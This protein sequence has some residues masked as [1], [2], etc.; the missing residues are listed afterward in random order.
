MTRSA[1]IRPART[2]KS[3][4]T[5]LPQLMATAVEANPTGAALILAA[6]TSTCERLSYEEL[7]ERSTRLARLLIDRG[8]GP[9]CLVAVGISR[10]IDSVVAVWAV[11]KSGAAF[12]PV[13]P[14][15]PK[16]A[17]LVADSGALL[18]LTVA[19]EQ[20]ALPE[21]I[22]WLRIDSIDT[23][24]ELAR[25]SSEP[26][27]YADRLHPLRAEHPAY[28]VYPGGTHREGVVVTQAGLAGL[29]AELHERFRVGFD[30]RTLHLAAPSSDDSIM[31][32]LLA[33]GG[34]AAMVVVASD[35]VG[36]A[37]LGGLLRREGVTH[38]FMN[39]AA[40][41][42]V[43]PA[44]LDE[45]RVVVA[46]GAICPPELSRRWARPGR[47]FYHGYG[48]TEAT[49]ITNIG[50]PPSPDGPATIGGP[51]RGVTEY[52]LD[53]RL[54][55]VPT[56][57]DGELYIA[58]AQQARGYHDRPGATAERFVANPFEPGSR[59][60]RT[61][62]LVRRAAGNELEFPGRNDFQE[63]PAADETRLAT[64]IH[65]QAPDRLD[66]DLLTID[67]RARILVDWNDTAHPVPAEL[68]LDGYR[69]A[70]AAHPEA[71]AVSFEGVEL[72][73]GEFD[74]R[75]NRLAR[76]LISQGVGAE[77]LVGLAVRRS[78]D[79]VVGMYAIVTA[80]GA[81]VPLDPDHP[82]ER[83]ARI[84]E[85]A[86]LDCVLTT[87]AD[88]A[89]VAGA[90]KVLA[91][92]TLD[93]AGYDGS[94]VA[95]H[96]LL[97]PVRPHHPAY[98]V[99]TSEPAGVVVSH[100]AI[101]NRI[102][103]MSAEYS[104]D[105]D[106][107]Y[108]HRAATTL[109]AAL[110]GLLLPL[111][112]GA[113]L[114]VATPDGRND[115]AYLAEVIAAREVTVT[116]FAPS[117]LSAFAEHAEAGS[118]PSLRDVFVVGAAPVPETVAALLRVCDA[119]VHSL[120]G[121]AEAA[122]SIACLPVDYVADHSSPIGVPQWNSQVYV[123]DSRLRPVPVGVPGEL[124][125]AGD[126]LARGYAHR[127][128]HTADRFVANPFGFGERIFRT[129]DQVVWR[130]DSAGAGVLNYVGRTE[131]EAEFSV[132]VD[133][134]GRAQLETPTATA[135]DAV[136]ISPEAVAVAPEAVVISPEVAVVV[137][138]DAA[139]PP[140]TVVIVADAVVTAPP[141]VIE[142]PPRGAHGPALGAI[143]RPERLPLSQ[144]QQRMWF[145]NRFDQDG[146]GSA[147]YNLPFA[148]RL[149][150]ELDLDALADA[151][152]EV[153]ARH[154]IL[155][156]VYPET[157]DGPIQV[158]LS[159]A[160]AGLA[161]IPR[162]IAADQ[163]AAAVLESAVAPF[164]VTV[165]TPMR[166]R[167]FQITDAP[168][169]Y[170]LAVVVYRIAAD[171][172]SLNLLM[173]DVLVAYTAGEALSREPLRVQYADYALWQRAVL[174]D[175]DDAVSIAGQQMLFWRTELAGV[176]NLLE[177]PTDRPRPAVAT[178]AAARVAMSIDAETR[179]ALMDLAGAHGATLSTVVRT[180]FAVVLARLSG[181]DDIAIGSPIA[182]RA[183]R[184]L[185]DLIGIFGNTLVLRTRYAG[186]ASF[187]ELLRR[188]RDSD[189]RAFAHA[190]IP[191]E[192]VVQ[193]LNPRRSTAH[194]PVFQ[195][196]LSFQNPTRTALELPGLSV[197]GIDVD[198]NVSQFDLHLI[199]GADHDEPGDPTGIDGFLTY[200]TDLFDAAT[201]SGFVARLSTVLT[202]VLADPDQP[203]GAIDMLTRAERTD[204]LAVRNATAHPVDPA[205]TLSTL[206]DRTVA[207]HAAA[208][209]LLDDATRV[210]LTY[211][212]L[213]NRANL[214]ARH[215]IALGVGPESRV[216][217]A[218]RRS[219]HLVVAMYAVT[220]AGGV[221]VPIDPD[222]PADRTAYILDTVDPIRIITDAATGFRSAS[223]PVLD[224][225]EFDSSGL[226]SAPVTQQDRRAPLTAD[227]I[228][229]LVF[230]SGSTGRPKG[231]AV[232]HR[233]IVNQL[234]WKTAEFD[235][236]PREVFL[237]KTVATF[238]LSVWEFWSAAIC[239][240]RLVVAAPDGHRDPTYL[241]ELV[242]RAGVTTLHAV[243]SLLDAL[244]VVDIAP[245]SPLRRILAI[246][247]A[248][249]AA[250]ATGLR[251][252][253]PRAALWNLYGPTEAAVSCTAHR[254][255][256][257]DIVAVPIGAPEWNS[258]VYVLDARLMPV[259]VG[260]SGELYLSGTQLAR[261]YFGRPDLTA[262]RF[263]AD[264]FQYGARMYR[265]GDLVAWNAGG[266][267][268]YR[269]RSDS[270][271]K[272]RGFRI[273]LGE[274][275]A[276]LLAL[277]EIAQAAVLVRSD[278]T[279]A[280]LV[281][282]AVAAAPAAP[283]AANLK[284]ALAEVLPSHMV[285]SA[286][287]ILDALPRNDN[288]KLDR[289]ALP[290]PEFETPAHRAPT[291][292]IEEV[293]AE[294]YGRVLGRE[295]IG[296]EDDFFALGGD[297][298]LASRVVARLGA[299]LDSR[300]PVRALFQAPTVA[301]LAVRVAHAAVGRLPLRARSRPEEIPLSQAQRRMWLLNQFGTAA[302]VPNIP[303]A[304]RL[305]GELD[306][307]ALR[308]AIA[309]VLVRHE[310]LRTVYPWT[311]EGPV[312]RVLPPYEAAIDLAPI[313]IGEERV[314]HEV[315][316]MVT[317]GFDVTGE[318]PL[319]ARLFQLG[320]SEYVLAVVV[321]RIGADAWSTG[322]LTRD[323][324]LAYRARAESA[325]PAWTPLPVQYADY[326]LWQRD[327]LA[328]DSD[329]ATPAGQQL[330]Y[331]R[332]EL[333]GLPDE[334]VLPVDRPRT[335]A[336]SFVG[337][338]VEFTV[339]AEVHGAL[340]RL[341][342]AHRATLFTVVRTALAVLLAR[343]SGSADIAV[344]TPVAGRGE[345]ELD[346][347]IGAFANTLVL[348]TE[349][350]AALS[351]AELLAANRET[352]LRAFANADIP[353]ERLVELRA[354]Q[355]FTGRHPLVQVALSFDNPVA[356]VFELSGL[357]FTPLGAAPDIAGFDLL[358]TIG[359]RRG[360]DGSAAGLVAE[361]GYA[362]DLFDESTVVDLGRR[363]RRVLAATAADPSVPVGDI[364]L[365]DDAER[366][367][368]LTRT[369]GPAVA[370]RTLPELMAAAAA[371]NPGA[372]ALI[373]EGRAFGYGDLDAAS[374]QLARALIDRGAG[375]DVL[376]ALALRRS[377][378][379]V[380][381]LWAVAKT[382]AAFLPIDPTYPADRIAHMITDSGVALGI[383]T[384]ADILSLP[385]LTDGGWVALDDRDFTVEV[386]TR[387]DA[388]LTARELRGPLRPENAAYV[389]YTSGS[390]GLPK[391]VVVTHAGLANF[392]AEQVERYGL[393]G[394]TRA[395]SFAA[396]AFDAVVLELLLAL[397]AG[398]A[399]VLTPPLLGGGAELAELIRRERVTHA[400]LTP[401]VLAALD[402]AALVGLRVV[403]SGGEAL[404]ADLAARW[405]E[406][407][408][409]RFH[410]GYGPTET[411][412]MTNISPPLRAGEPPAL[413]G[414]IR[415]TRSLVLDARLRPVPEGV[416]GELYLGGVQLARGYLQRRGLTAAR[417]VADPFGAPGERLYRT[418]DVVR[419]RRG[420]AVLDYVG[421]ND[422]QV[423]VRGLRVELGE[424]DA[425]LTTRHRVDFS[426]TVAHES[427]TGAPM[428]VSYVR[429][430][431]GRFLDTALL[432]AELARTLPEQMVPAA[433]VVLDEIPL[434]PVGKL[435]R[436]ALP[437]PEFA[438]PAYRAPGTIAAQTIAAAMG[439]VLG[440]ARV[441]LD[442]DFFALGGDS[443]RAIRV[444]SR[445]REDGVDFAPHEI[446]T[447]RTVGAL[448][449][450]ATVAGAADE[451]GELP[452]TA[453]AAR[454]VA[455]G[456]WV[457]VRALTL[458]VPPNCP[459][460]AVSATVDAVLDQHPLLW[461][462]LTG[463][464]PA[465]RIPPLAERDGEH[466]GR[467]DPER[468]ETALPLDD[469]VLAAAAALDPV[470][471]RNIHFVLSGTTL[472]VVANGLVV[473]D[474]SWRT[475]IDQLTAA[476]NRGR[477]AAPAVPESGVG[478]LVAGLHDRA[479]AAE[480]L[481]EIPWWERTLGPTSGRSANPGP[482]N[483][484]S[485]A[486]TAE[487]TEAVAAV[488]EAYH[489]TV[490]DVLLTAVA[491]AM[492]TGADTA[493]A[494]TVGPVV[495]L[496]ADG[497][498]I[499]P[500][501][502]DSM[503][504]GFTTDYPMRLRLDGIDAD[505]AL[506]GGPAAG[507]ALAAV[508]E[509]RRAVPSG[510][511][512]YGLLRHLNPDAAQR[513]SAL[514]SGRL[515][516]RYRDLR[517]ARVHTD[518]PAED[519]LLDLTV[520]ATDEGLL[521]RFDYAV[522]AFGANE[523][524]AFAEHWI[525]AL[526]GLAEHGLRTD[527]GGFG[528]S[529]FPLVSL[530]QSEIN[531]LARAYPNLSDIWPLT[532][533][534]SGIA[535]HAMLADGSLDMYITQFVLDLGGTVDARRLRAAAQAVLDR[536]DNLRVAFAADDAGNPVQVVQDSVEAP[537]RL[538]EVNDLD[539]AEADRELAAVEA[540][541]L[542]EH[543]EMGAAPLLRFTLIRS[544][545]ATDGSGHYH[546]L[547]TS[548]HI[549]VDSWSM[550]LLTRD[551]LTCYAMGAAARTRPH[552]PSYRAYLAWLAEQ[553]RAAARTAWR[554]SLAGIAGPTPLAPV[555]PGREIASGIGE[556]A[557]ELS[558]ADTTALT[559]LAAGLGVTA[560]TVVQAAWGL[561]VGR[562]IDRDD[563]VIGATVSGRPPE[564]SGVESM[565]GLFRTVIPVRVRLGATDTLGGLLRQLQT[566]QAALLDHHHLGLSEIQRTIGTEGLFDSLVVFESFPVDR[567]GLEKAGAVDGMSVI[568]VDAVNGTHYPLTVT[569]V[570]D[571]Q[572]RVTLKYLRDLFD[573]GAARRLA[574]RL[575]TLIGRFADTPQARIADI[576]ILLDAER[577]ALATVNA[578]TDMPEL[579]DEST[580]LT[581]FD[582]QVA[583]TPYAPAVRFGETVLG[584][585]DLDARSRVLAAELSR[586]GVGPEALVAVAM[587]RGIDLVVA[588]YAVL[589]AG[590]GYVPIDPDQPVE[591]SEQVLDSAAPICVLTTTADGFT[592]A[593]GVQ[594][595]AV[596][597]LYLSV[598]VVP[599]LESG[600]RADNIAYVV[601]TSGSTGRPEGVATTH[602]Q[603]VNQFRWAQQ[604]YPHDG[605][606]TVLHKTP[607]TFDI[608]AWELLWPLQTGASIV[609]AAPDGHR[610]PAYLARVIVENRVSTAHFVPSMLA[611][612]LDGQPRIYPSLRRVFAAG[613]ALSAATAAAFAA[614]LLGTEL[615]NWYGLAEATVVTA[616]PATGGAA[617][618][619]PIGTPVANTR[620]HVL[621]RHL[622]PVPPGAP[623]ELYLS[624]VQLARGYLDAPARTAERFVAHDG[625][626]RLYRTGDMV[627]WTRG[628][629]ALEYLGRGE[630]QVEM[631]GRRVELGEIEAVLAEDDAVRHVAVAA[632]RVANG[633]RLVAY[634][635]AAQGHSIDDR[636][637]LAHA[638][639]VLPAHMIPAA[640]V[641]LDTFP[642]TA[643]G[644]FDRRALPVPNL[645]DQYRPPTTPLERTIAEVYAEVL[646]CDQIG[647]DDDFFDLGGNSLLAT[648]AVTRLRAATGAEIRVQWLFTDPD[649]AALAARIA[650]AAD[651]THDYDADSNAALGV[652]LPI[653]TRV[654]HDTAAAEP[655]FCL[656]PMYGLSWCYA[657]LARYVPA[658][659]PIYGLQ[660]PALSEEGY[661]PDSPAQ[662]VARY[663]AE[664]RAV[665]P[666]G[667]YRLL[668][669]SFGGV[670]A[671]AVA[672]ALQADGAQVALLVMLDSH[673][674]IDITDFRAVVREALG[675]LGIGA[676]GLLPADGTDVHDLT[677]AALTALH[678]TIPADMAVLTPERVRRIY[679]SAVRSA[680]L[681]AA[682]R[683]PVFRGELHYFSAVGPENAAANW[684]RY[685]DG[686][687]ADHPVGVTHDQMT[688]PTA[689]GE[690]GP[691]LSKLLDPGVSWLGRP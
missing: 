270:Q 445:C 147:A 614:D 413:G 517:P 552:V 245:V 309:D 627:R 548:H 231:V 325:A 252:A 288:G 24:T 675:E 687:I 526:G 542:A 321:H 79:L 132:P 282:Y 194:H 594:V 298:L 258:R 240:G 374:A 125:L 38:A 82:A 393:D 469:V 237:L 583:R 4:V 454:L 170:V 624:G 642:L 408:E 127:S 273:E 595:V 358:L 632:V 378:E 41:T 672:A 465:L 615:I 630:F 365:V 164:D 560:N 117:M 23:A 243:P 440:V 232:S 550:P 204:L 399:L 584:Y 609:L 34:A 284:S 668:G 302:A 544:G 21:A 633:I 490:D 506:I 637:L 344:G 66:F 441:G 644:K 322:P 217:L 464:A 64:P 95:A 582:A 228:A 81:Y 387:S 202:A 138:E 211:R 397:G 173:R 437:R 677:D 385:E 592:T 278:R 139:T 52:V 468:G 532:P 11:A 534:Q 652:L 334:L 574:H 350:A 422:F 622:R 400:F 577:T 508:K 32:L 286:F 71:V 78:L 88:A 351:F 297:S 46:G 155:R 562:S 610:D 251:A 686:E 281:A 657:G 238:D 394:Q 474:I 533:T 655:L 178:M 431:P 602:R 466:F 126:Q 389:C 631:R 262:E 680:E 31:E 328:A 363:F 83:T 260:V 446:F 244:L 529:D 497:R 648:R 355:R 448:A 299:L 107:V 443:F 219:V 5:T 402:S 543:F 382:G 403:V 398:G 647:L 537:W 35:V 2:R 613:E 176:P 75:V 364:D 450:I 230:T 551:L 424:I 105:S 133:V 277:P 482:R 3:R 620:V 527:T 333:A 456:Q 411:T 623:G 409:R 58:G 199:L 452:L 395:L 473:D 546:L 616:H 478:T 651:R 259:P 275:E 318:I 349:V 511:R 496:S 121:P 42:S 421:R 120:Y 266:E 585:A 215:L 601:H 604:H 212:E 146:I 51:I 198:L 289:K 331:W 102:A 342:R 434:S 634:V 492:H 162:P 563:V 256:S 487:G 187:T 691:R 540:A 174:G 70:V 330:E 124:Y 36:G 356:P 87:A 493:V 556:V 207:T 183:E 324:V 196:G 128:D 690:I 141:A 568:G 596:D 495:R 106:D 57:A 255:G 488:A 635:V 91:L 575:S 151:I 283:E 625:G 18:G 269:G 590:G 171:T 314:A 149:T 175:E 656:H 678:A 234:L 547:I 347:L 341:A 84:L 567:E 310:V 390:T 597:T 579:R 483:R 354:P 223:I 353:F 276:A 63:S 460:D 274:I 316:R 294:V 130:E 481:A 576:D 603:L 220:K 304:I 485:L 249:P 565:I 101:N 165:E 329:P 515:A 140:E 25:Y 521:V 666:S 86:Q 300:V 145:L 290:D 429:P 605:T 343:L 195:V 518:A 606:D 144:A 415:G 154:E 572:L 337:G 26:I 112:V 438:A 459:A 663:V 158:V 161:V 44:G 72:S 377:I 185:E 27:G 227:H 312:Q 536:H 535:F 40:L 135:P 10:S 665:Q 14:A 225:D 388:P 305:S 476:W 646:R 153:V 549:L 372:P 103:W 179:A 670:L 169:E 669:W 423:Q 348:R 626:E 172:S 80:G 391:G 554:T 689:L 598:E 571:N 110:L 685:V 417:F 505:D 22:D 599:A 48:P 265:T 501:R 292:P 308:A 233:A 295:R 332:G 586:W 618:S 68:L 428:L 426:V 531:R 503:V 150:G 311:L 587:R 524:K 621:D 301:A 444:V 449:E 520:D 412:I 491:L 320:G 662:L 407:G 405:A 93:T 291:T 208:V 569:V 499:G 570:L 123:L 396:P 248:L 163:V 92:D 39:P 177:L 49:T 419:W 471:G 108:L 184:E 553:D 131:V 33:L 157:I 512:G 432:T 73:Y 192:R 53:E 160:Q 638:R 241:A 56:G 345:P 167:L 326:A 77:S 12:V 17:Y 7:D 97:R 581:L 8:I 313:P 664:I 159:A 89:A 619:V 47:E 152:E 513:L 658:A 28:V 180:A 650:E 414:P 54:S 113:K 267:L 486:I 681:V 479:F 19:A 381:A 352:D 369:G 514:E 641:L 401:S 439:E 470:A 213:D 357:S 516:L 500:D 523:V 6:A 327:L 222:Q 545:A 201:A 671:H 679:R 43:D 142:S 193:V 221:Y 203:V 114:V 427:D 676:A 557:F 370:P 60:Y 319:R 660:S 148:L 368:L 528:P 682:H 435:D 649:V 392:G 76:L 254:V 375:P 608:A 268:E 9:E 433:V 236:G 210:E 684:V 15:D 189:L 263:L 1:R 629:W 190:D 235:L 166:V 317:E 659:F 45:L 279:G 612:F 246:G 271:V 239:G 489:T 115:P 96:E 67:E 336:P 100:V 216:V 484:V 654:P 416:A 386:A 61:G 661:L 306:T 566:E 628:V 186:G 458:D 559:R 420:S 674:E 20:A 367:D 116:D 504:G 122:V 564:L 257:A 558:P 530:R 373:A 480:T 463:T 335:A 502:A 315:S 376:V 264:P 104:L 191:F 303:I 109:D 380:L 168:D 293:V 688:S 640:V 206:L 287:V 442:D 359:E 539:P 129:G 37:A 573:A 137:P 475:V 636:A 62:D 371:L 65:P 85:T 156:T 90:A 507:A 538:V 461:A 519:L 611:A 591:Y 467:L 379:S 296:V 253:Y 50:A 94:P 55:R 250:L 361:F 214:L 607:I 617:A 338:R 509:A 418:G 285:P 477:H 451:S 136:V 522:A 339:D 118:L 360:E 404:P 323:V 541:D 494:R 653:R 226:D 436:R 209:A 525:R 457:E 673:P 561:L 13:D 593:S 643:N 589:R 406:V 447:R 346:N 340:E 218:L 143:E 639:A 555:D 272:I 242:A 510:G 498:G 683:P 425:A 181:A 224:L 280:R 261:G 30:S 645:S 99:F 453:T 200:A 182:G 667:P 29:C 578:D 600:V 455:E 588:I 307:A 188:Q 362:R 462:R 430:S 111:R 134:S 229:Y 197:A 205:A 16:A 366:A 74:G 98:V 410:N 383:T 59:L 247:E 580:L 472:V 69:R 384:A 119:E